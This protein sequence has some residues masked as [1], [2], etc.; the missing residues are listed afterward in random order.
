[1]GGDNGRKSERGGGGRRRRGRNGEFNEMR[2]KKGMR[3]LE[4][5][6]DK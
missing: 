4:R 3:E 6:R 5:E 2:K 1:M